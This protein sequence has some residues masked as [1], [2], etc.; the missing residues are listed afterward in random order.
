MTLSSLPEPDAAFPR[1]LSSAELTELAHMLVCFKL[2]P[3]ERRGFESPLINDLLE[4]AIAR[5]PSIPAAME[6]YVRPLRD[7]FTQQMGEPG[8]GNRRS[9]LASL[10]DDAARRATTADFFLPLWPRAEIPLDP[11]T[12]TAAAFGPIPAPEPT[13][14][15]RISYAVVCLKNKQIHAHTQQRN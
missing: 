7:A 12:E 4:Q 15:R 10:P 5:D 13:R 1:L 8:P 14:L 9:F 3:E 6:P 11:Y 2:I